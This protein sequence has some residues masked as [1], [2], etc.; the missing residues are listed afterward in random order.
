MNRNKLTPLHGCI[1]DKEMT[2]DL[3]ESTAIVNKLSSI[4]GT[5]DGSEEQAKKLVAK[6]ELHIRNNKLL[7]N[8]VEAPTVYE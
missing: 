7:L 1:A 8:A 6:I 4:I 2:V 3:L 5:W